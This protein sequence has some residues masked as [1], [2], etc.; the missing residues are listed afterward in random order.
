MPVNSAE[1]IKDVASAVSADV[2][3]EPGWRSILHLLDEEDVDVMYKANAFLA[4][5]SRV[6]DTRMKAKYKV[7]DAIHSNGKYKI[8]TYSIEERERMMGLPV[9]Y[10]GKPLG[11][12]F[13]QLCENAFQLPETVV[14]KTYRECFCV[15]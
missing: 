7:N 11:Y 8:E 10:V 15:H 3:L 12:I 6:D 14:G 1:H 5:L 13:K 2:C 4:S 9:G